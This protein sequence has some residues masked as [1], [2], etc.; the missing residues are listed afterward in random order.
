[1][2]VVGMK[3]LGLL[4]SDSTKPMTPLIVEMYSPVLNEVLSKTPKT[5]FEFLSNDYTVHSVAT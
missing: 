4:G 1:M 2:H 5:D 3:I